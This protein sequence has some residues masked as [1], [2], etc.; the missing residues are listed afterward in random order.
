MIFSY[1]RLAKYKECPWAFYKKYILELPEEPTEAQEQGKAVHRVI[2]EVLTD[3]SATLADAAVRACA[4]AV[5][6]LDPET[7][8]ELAKHPAVEQVRELAL[9]GG[10]VEEH[11]ELPLDGPGS[12]VLQGY[13]DL[14]WEDPAGATLIDWKTNRATY[15]PRDNHQLGLYAWSIN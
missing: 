14:W 1:S 6:P 9:V 11:F 15:N 12:P 3:S 10:H 4:E 7:V 8:M 2:Q 5:L 13:I